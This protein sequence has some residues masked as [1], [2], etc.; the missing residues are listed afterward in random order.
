MKKCGIKEVLH[1]MLY[2]QC[3]RGLWEQVLVIL[4]PSAPL[5][6]YFAILIYAQH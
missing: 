6:L 2:L 4:L 3:Y 1:H 5:M